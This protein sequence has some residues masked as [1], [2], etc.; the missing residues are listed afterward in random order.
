VDNELLEAAKH[1]SKRSKKRKEQFERKQKNQEKVGEYILELQK[2]KM[3]DEDRLLLRSTREV[4]QTD[5]LKQKLTK[6]LRRHKAGLELSADEMELLF[7]NEAKSEGSAYETMDDDNNMTV[8]LVQPSTVINVP[9]SDI[10]MSKDSV[11]E[12]T[13]QAPID[14]FSLIGASTSQVSYTK[15]SSKPKK[16]KSKSK[17]QPSSIGSNLLQQLI[18]LPSKS[19]KLNK[20]PSMTSSSRADLTS[21][22]DVTVDAGVGARKSSIDARQDVQTDAG[23]ERDFTPYIPVPIENPIEDY[24]SII[25]RNLLSN[26]SSFSSTAASS[27]ATVQTAIQISRDPTIQSQRLSLPVC[28]MEQ[29]IVE[30][31]SSNDVVILCSETGSGK[32]T[33]VP[34][35][36]YE[37]GYSRHG[38]IGQLL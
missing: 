28:G 26:H 16:D 17:S 18:N 6:L 24:T 10:I 37:Y 9:E 32:S 25:K 8:S 13:D 5:T 22:A 7:P 19:M 2:Y 23:N 30:A 12:S 27:S 20:D 35:F 36:L 34:Q 4:G 14:I 11:T 38:Y 3:S 31:I 1:L 29:E 21:H 15:T 33:Q